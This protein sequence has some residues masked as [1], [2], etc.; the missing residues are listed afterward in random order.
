[1]F[2]KLTTLFLTGSMLFLFGCCGEE[3]LER[4]E[5]LDKSMLATVSVRDCGATT[6]EYTGVSLKSRHFWS[7]EETIFSTKYDTRLEVRWN[8]NSELI[9]SCRGCKQEEIRI[10]KTKL[11]SVNI[12]YSLGVAAL[13]GE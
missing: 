8:S 2:I 10:Q 1:M 5:S 12:A 7:Q 4:F 6:S 3:T 9:I 13:K 11:G